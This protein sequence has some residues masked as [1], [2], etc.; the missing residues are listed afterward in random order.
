VLS[1]VL[2]DARVLGPQDGWRAGFLVGAVL[3][4]AILLVRRHVPESPRWL[5]AHGRADEAERVMAG[6]R[7]GRGRAH[8][9]AAS[10]RCRTAAPALPTW[11]EVVA[12]CCCTATGSAAWWC[13]R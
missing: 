13:W 6:H 11:R 4:V 1:L 10:L 7:G 8:A 9:C 3:A 12:T 2:L 5:L